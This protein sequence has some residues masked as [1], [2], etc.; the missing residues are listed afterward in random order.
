MYI[1]YKIDWSFWRKR[2][3]RTHPPLIRNS[4]AVDVPKKGLWQAI[5]G[6]VVLF[7]TLAFFGI[8]IWLAWDALI[9]GDPLYFTHSQFSASSQQQGWLTRGE[10]P[11]Y[12]NLWLSLKYYFV[13]AMNNCGVLPFFVAVIGAVAY[14]FQKK[15]AH[16]ILISCVLLTPFIFYVVTLYLGQSVIFI[17]HLTPT[18]FDW[19]LFNARYGV[20]MV[21]I[22]AVFLGYL[23]WRSRPGAKWLIAFLML[24]QLGL[25]GIGYSPILSYRDG[26]VGLSS[27]KRTD[28]EAWMR[29]NYDGGLVLMDDFART[30]S[31]TRSLIP[32][33]N[34]I[35]IGNK[36]YWEES[37]I[38]PEKYATWIIMQEH[39]TVWNS[40]LDGGA[41]E[42]R[43]YKYFAKA[44]TSPNI[45][46]FKRS[47]EIK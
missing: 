24:A 4:D 41:V 15:N 33:Q 11:A 12:H 10:L 1:P 18:T 23:F 46:I 38:A 9:L 43:L 45:L 20:M 8:V 3:W 22:T 25:Y 19:T 40:L 6:R 2:S 14:V 37:L 16:R 39:D 36:P 21:P 31:V 44:Y 26:T 34:T 5:E 32:M 29:Q 27:S 47:S 28:A 35:Y 13:T 17:P 7:A 30:M 42:G